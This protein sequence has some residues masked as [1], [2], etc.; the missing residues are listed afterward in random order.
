[1]SALAILVQTAKSNIAAALA[2]AQQAS[3]PLRHEHLDTA[4]AVLQSGGHL[5]QAAAARP[6]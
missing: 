5:E 1:M 2:V 3:P 4:P 6:A